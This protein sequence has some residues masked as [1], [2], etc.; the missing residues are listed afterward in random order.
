VIDGLDNIENI[1]K[2]KQAKFE[3]GCVDNKGFLRI[4]YYR[5]TRDVNFFAF[6]NSAALARYLLIILKA[7]S[8]ISTATDNSHEMIIIKKTW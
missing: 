3:D 4:N 5:P 6:L 2:A 1:V 7:P 8:R